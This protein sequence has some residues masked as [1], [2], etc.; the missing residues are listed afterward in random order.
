MKRILVGGRYILAGRTLVDGEEAAIAIAI[1]GSIITTLSA[2]DNAVLDAIA[3]SLALLDNAVDGNYHNVNMNIA[4]IDV[5][6][7][8]GILAAGVQRV[9]IATDDEVNNFL[10]ILAAAV[11]GGQT[12]WSASENHTSAQTNNELVAAPGS[13]LSLYITDVIIS[14]GAVAGNIKFLED[15]GTPGV[16]KIE[17]LYF[18]INSGTNIRFKTPIKITAEKNF[19]FTS[20]SMTTHSITVNG[21]TAA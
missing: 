2:V 7:G 12:I 20:V 4:G 11:P 13:G 9:T 10:G 8:S 21:Y 6:G 3:A 15:T 16:D 5:V 14:N 1:D 18:G 19:G 17:V